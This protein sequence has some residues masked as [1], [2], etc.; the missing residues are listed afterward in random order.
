MMAPHMG[1]GAVDVR[2]VAAAH[3]AA[4]ATPGASGQR[5]ITSGHSI[6]IK[7]MV[8][9]VVKSFPNS[10]VYVPSMSPPSLLLWALAPYIGMGRRDTVSKSMNRIPMFDN[11]KIQKDLGL[12]FTD[13]DETVKDMVEAMVQLQI[14]KP[15]TARA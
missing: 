15:L 11:T 7:Q 8:A 1:F 12:H 9:S 14:I 4:M 2:D 3:C 13:F 10:R 5:Y 6:W